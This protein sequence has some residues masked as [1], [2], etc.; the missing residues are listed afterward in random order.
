MNIGGVLAHTPNPNAL[1][2]STLAAAVVA[3][4]KALAE[5]GRAYGVTVSGVNPGL[6]E[7]G[8]LRQNL[9]AQMERKNN[10][11]PLEHGAFARVSYSKWASTGSARRRISPTSLRFFCPN[12]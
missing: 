7:T 11:S 2:G 5:Q 1:I 4:T 8:R 3:L 10:Q 12:A 9:E 6:I